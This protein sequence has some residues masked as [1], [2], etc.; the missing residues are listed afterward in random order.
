MGVYMAEIRKHDL[1]SRRR[2]REPEP[3]PE[4]EQ[5]QEAEAEV[6]PE[7]ER[8][9][10]KKPEPETKASA[11]A[12][13]TGPL[14]RR[15]RKPPE[16][17][18]PS[19]ARDEKKKE[20][21]PRQAQKR[22]GTRRPA[23][24]RKA[25]SRPSGSQQRPKITNPIIGIPAGYKRFTHEDRHEYEYY[26]LYEPYVS[27]IHKAGGIPIIIPVG[28]EGRYSNRI[29]ELIDGLLL[30]G[31][32][33]IDPNL[34]GDLL[35]SKLRNVEPKNDLT[36]IELFNLAFN[37][38]M[39]I[40]GICRG[41]QIMNVALDGT[42]YQDIT[43]QVRMA[44][45]HDPD[46]PH[47]EPCHIVDIEDETKLRRI[48]EEEEIRTNSWHHQGIKLHGKG[49]LVN[50][51]ASDGIIEGVEHPNKKWVIG[52]QWHAELMWQYDKI[53]AKLFKAFVDACKS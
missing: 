2:K 46:F 8:E 28:L 11:P 43:S 26:Y 23:P 32:G 38:N 6:K 27:A 51:R 9:T 39:P 17:P 40:L 14:S 24:A 47:E 15:R 18:K 25:P 13:P 52:V 36:E 19:P 3:E 31:G 10:E 30:A 29:L 7:P 5:K 16:A 20:S 45:N 49:L 12:R 34:Y 35:T 22:T 50:A 4:Q 53:Q 21:P 48:L 37:K 44:L 41:A 1:R 42:L 33:D